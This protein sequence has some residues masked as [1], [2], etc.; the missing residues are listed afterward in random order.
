MGNKPRAAVGECGGQLG[1]SC[2][3]PH[4][5]ER[6]HWWVAWEWRKVDEVERDLSTGNHRPS[7]QLKSC[8][9]W[10]KGNVRGWH[11][12]FCL[13]N[14][15]CGTP[16]ELQMWGRGGGTAGPAG[17]WWVRSCPCVVV[18][19]GLTL[20]WEVPVWERPGSVVSMLFLSKPWYRGN[21]QQGNRLMGETLEKLI[22]AEAFP[23]EWRGLQIR[24]QTTR[25][26]EA[27]C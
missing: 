13:S 19:T 1:G 21:S 10:K 4:P 20:R 3:S 23:K 26:R 25:C 17:P 18:R 11:L 22:E 16:T 5:G 6:T 24:T 27:G 15:A 14:H 9:G 12:D 8:R 7:G 2:D